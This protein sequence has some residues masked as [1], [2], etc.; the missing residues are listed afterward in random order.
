MYASRSM[1]ECERRY[2]QIEREALA[3]TWACEKFSMYIIGLKFDL[4]TDHRPLVPLLSEIPISDLSARLQRFR[5]RLRNFNYAIYYVPGKELYVPDILSRQLQI[6]EIGTIE[7]VEERLVEDYVRQEMECFQSHFVKQIK[8]AQKDDT[9]YLKCKAYIESDWPEKSR[10][11]AY[12]PF[13]NELVIHEGLLL[14]GR[15][16]WVPKKLRQF[17]LQK[18]HEG[19]Q[20]NVKTRRRAAE[21]PWWVGINSDIEA[22]VENCEVCA[23]KRLN[24]AEPLIPSQPPEGPWRKIGVDFC[25]VK[26]RKFLVVMDYFSKWIEVL[27]MKATTAVQVIEKM[28]NVFARYG[29]PDIVRA[30]NG[31]P[32]DSTQ[33]RHFSTEWN[34]C[35]VTSSPKFS[36]SNGQAER[37]VKIVKDLI[38]DNVCISEALLAYRATPLESGFSPA[39]LLLGRRTKSKLPCLNSWLEPEWPSTEAVKQKEVEL[40]ERQAKN[41]DERHGVRLQK[42]LDEGQRV[43]I[44]DMKREGKVVGPA[45]TPRSYIIESEGGRLRRN[46]RDIAILPKKNEPPE[47]NKEAK[48]EVGVRRS[49][50]TRTKSMYTKK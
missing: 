41:F 33:F 28:K 5:M 4:L 16:I 24:R 9:E 27:E 22:F 49:P 43:W 44:P 36:Q 29:V 15:R 2:A 6:Q 45:E 12:H 10:K 46:R 34:F 42:H 13:K 50:R 11:F 37:G 1:S 32:F 39:Q 31:P 18:L 3:L 17:H 48:D 21:C 14:K 35:L 8:E 23:R 38:K 40:K 25:E 7:A 19:H 26:N 20:G 47:T 30:D